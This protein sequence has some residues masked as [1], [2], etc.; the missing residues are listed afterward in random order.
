VR[1]GQRMG[2]GGRSEREDNPYPNG[3]KGCR[4]SCIWCRVGGR[5]AAKSV[6]SYLNRGRSVLSLATPYDGQSGAHL[7]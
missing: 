7:V 1:V 5:T 4:L 6:K 2:G 3:G